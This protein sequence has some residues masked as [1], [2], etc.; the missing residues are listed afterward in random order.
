MGEKKILNKM[1]FLLYILFII[2]FTIKCNAYCDMQECHLYC[3]RKK[4]KKPSST[5][6]WNTCT[7][8][9]VCQ[10]INLPPDSKNRKCVCGYNL[11]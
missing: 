9:G 11:T 4:P 1:K 7:Y 10:P 8:Y 3:I 2:L 5:S 6:G